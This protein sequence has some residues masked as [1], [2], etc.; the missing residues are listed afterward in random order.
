M[1]VAWSPDDT[2][3]DLAPLAPHTLR[4]LPA[5]PREDAAAGDAP[6]WITD[7][8]EHFVHG[9]KLYVRTVAAFVVAPRRSAEA[10]ANGR[11]RA[12]N[13]MSYLLKGLAIVM[14]WRALWWW[15]LG[16]PEQSTAQSLAFEA[17]PYFYA[18]LA[19]A[20]AH[21]IF[22]SLGS[23]RPLRATWGAWMYAA[24]GGPLALMLLSE[25]VSAWRRHLEAT[26][27]SHGLVRV[28]GTT[29]GLAVF[30]SF[31]VYITLALA[32]IHGVR[33]R[34]ALVVTFG[35]AAATTVGALSVAIGVALV[36]QLIRR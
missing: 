11:L 33:R 6:A 3:R 24:G 28:L 10:W 32:G 29:T 14:P 19:G 16:L 20:V 12:V 13:P 30:V 21:A 23:R 5:L 8:I 27:G 9:V 15:K 34:R 25:P 17:M 31:I 4:M 35:A 1:T 36:V 18:V 7:G 22:G 2:V 26:G